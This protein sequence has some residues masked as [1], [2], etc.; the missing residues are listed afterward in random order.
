[1]RIALDVMGGDHA[2]QVT[3]EGAVMASK[4][5]PEIEIILIGPEDV[6]ERELAKHKD[7]NGFEVVHAREVIEMTDHPAQAVK[8]KKESS[9]VVGMQLLKKKEI[10]GFFS[11]GNTGGMLAA[12][13]LYLGRIRGVKRPALSALFPT[14]RG[15]TFL[16]DIGANADVKPD[17]LQQFALMGSL[18]AERVLK[19]PNPTVAIMSNGEEEG[20]GN[21]MVL[22]AYQLIKQLPINFMGNAEGRDLGLGNFDVI[23][24]DGFT[25]NIVIKTAE[26]L[27][28]MTKA[29]LKDA[30]KGD[31]LSMLAG[32][33]F[34]P[35]GFPRVKKATSADEIGG[36]PLLG[37]N[38]VVLVGHGSSSAYAI[39]NGIRAARDA[40]QSNI[41]AAITEGMSQVKVTDKEGAEVG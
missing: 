40:V 29:L 27:A 15:S 1:M 18:Y 19:R 22:E 3:I 5:Y 41:V 11:A 2:P 4:A 23:V 39:Q 16:L 21:E 33:L 32:A 7:H 12:G 30:F 37:L 9:M 31:P 24:T 38:G 25:G 17:F 28:T 20:K 36:A 13:I 35:L 34:M 6:I 10:D 8:T 14:M 26:G